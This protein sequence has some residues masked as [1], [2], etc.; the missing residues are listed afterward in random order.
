MNPN[1][2]VY[3]MAEAIERE[4]LDARAVRAHLATEAAA[5]R[6]ARSPLRSLRWTAG[7]ALVRAGAL[8][9]GSAKDIGTLRPVASKEAC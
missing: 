2:T 9:Q 1:L 5:R 4:L 3:A 6:P 8:L 7:A